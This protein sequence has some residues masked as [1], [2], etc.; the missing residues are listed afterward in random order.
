MIY[1]SFWLKLSACGLIQFHIIQ[2]CIEFEEFE[3][4][5]KRAVNYHDSVNFQSYDI[6]Q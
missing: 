2:L 6:V 3:I 1:D 4:L 5:Q